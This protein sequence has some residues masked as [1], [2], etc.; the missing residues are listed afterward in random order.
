MWIS[1]S[2][3][4]PEHAFFI[5]P[6]FWAKILPKSQM[7]SMSSILENFITIEPVFSHQT[8]KYLNY[9]QS[10]PGEDTLIVATQ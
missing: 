5:S 2:H 6:L 10:F 9:F 4:L 3:S 1:D 8:E 7:L